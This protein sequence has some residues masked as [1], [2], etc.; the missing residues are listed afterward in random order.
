[1]DLL[2]FK[3][4]ENTRLAYK[5]LIHQNATTTVIFLHGSTYNS[6]R[7]KNLAKSLFNHSINTCLLDWRGH[8]DSEGKP[9]DVAYIG[10]LED[11]LADFITHFS[12]HNSTKLILSGHSAGA[13]ICLRY[14]AKYGCNGISGVSFIAPAI[15]GPLETVRYQQKSAKWQYRV[16][17]FRKAQI[18]ALAPEAALKHAPSLKAWPFICAKALPVLRH[19]GILRFPANERMAK[20][21]KRVLNY[22][23]NLM[24]SCD[25]NNYPAAFNQISVPVLLLAG[26]LD[27]VIHPDLLKTIYHWHL[28]PQINK[29]IIE[30]PKVNHMNIVSVAAKVLP[31]WLTDL[32]VVDDNLDVRQAV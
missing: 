1:M 21:E 22:S 27:E 12:K 11:D 4:R 5:Q 19:K 23:Y 24:L 26:E 13:V 3:A 17:Y 20:L 15:N 18:Q 10:Q 2:F 28:S 7:Y 9:G 6:L 14:I 30:V 16:S 32:D 31:Q 8:G 29:Q 25:I